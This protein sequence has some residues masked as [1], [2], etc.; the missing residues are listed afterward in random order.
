V[1]E[2]MKKKFFD[3]NL[4]LEG[5]SQ[6]RLPGLIFLVVSVFGSGLYAIAHYFSYLNYQNQVT[7]YG[8]S[9]VYLQSMRIVD[10]QNTTP[11]L[12]PVAYLAPFVFCL[13]LFSFLNSRRGSDYYHALSCTRV[14]L[15]LSF[16]ASILIW[17][18][19][20]IVPSVLAASLI[21]GITGAIFNAAYI[22]C[23]I[24]TFFAAA[25]L[26]T[27]CMLVAMSITGTVFTNTI[28]FGLILF[29]PRFATTFLMSSVIGSLPILTTSAG[30][31]G[32]IGYN[33]PADFVYRYFMNQNSSSLD[34]LYTSI[35]SILYT[36]ILA[37]V[38][39]ALAC[40]LF[41]LRKSETAGAGA[42]NR[43]LQHV[44]RCIV[45]LPVALLIP[46]VL[47][48]YENAEYNDF[49]QFLEGQ[50]GT[51]IILAAAS[52]LIYFLYELLTTKSVKRMFRSAPLLLAVAAVCVLFGVTL[53]AVR[54]SLLNFSPSAGQIESV[55][56]LPLSEDTNRYATNSYES[57]NELGLKALPLTGSTLK[58]AVADILAG[59]VR[60]LKASVDGLYQS[61]YT[62]YHVGIRLKNGQ[63]A[64][65]ILYAAG[66][67]NAKIKKAL[68]A[69]STFFNAST[70]LPD[71]KSVDIVTASFDNQS[72]S[73]TA[74]KKLWQLFK[75]EYDSLPNEEK[76]SVDA[77]PGAFSN[78]NPILSVYGSLGMERFQNNYMIN[79]TLPKTEQFYA[80]LTNDRNKVK[81]K[82]LLSGYI[83]NGIG[84]DNLE[85]IFYNCVLKNSQAS[86]AAKN[87][88]LSSLVKST[89]ADQKQQICAILQ[90]QFG[91]TLDIH[92]PYVY[93]TLS[94]KDGTYSYY[95]PLSP[96][97]VKEIET[98]VT[99]KAS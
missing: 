69:N 14:C 83:K 43:I 22:P 70:A 29:L 42:P 80:K 54:S 38:Y 28:L 23:L 9:S 30:G 88:S 27:A 97:N 31:F 95:Q 26:V 68:Y 55:T 86:N 2:Q 93:V 71:E 52:I 96:D 40:F 33:I 16:T 10:I 81:A 66:A 94:A 20:I 12:L 99:V 89:S 35:P 25:V 51:I 7:R 49:R 48:S 5:F 34:A 11:L 57:Y 62:N 74:C 75:T 58:G 32:N 3:K 67:M 73:E 79:D 61:P 41:R 77:S 45:T 37:A 90:R 59:D 24:F 4:M 65:R 91:G 6:L 56:I 92:K 13:M 47:L 98:L 84:S 78:T 76:L 21:Y 15:F 1:I 36:L 53:N 8:G 64:E 18:A 85:V 63:Y 50:A 19:L 72:L 44:Y 17:L 60:S 39:I 46:I 82:S 87:F